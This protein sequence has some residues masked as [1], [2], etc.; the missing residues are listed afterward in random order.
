MAAS[1]HLVSLGAVTVA[2]LAVASAIWCWRSL[3][4][5]RRER[6]AMAEMLE[7]ER[8]QQ[9]AAATAAR[10]S[11][12][13]EREL[14]GLKARFVSLV[15]HEFRTPLGIIMSAVELLKNY[16]DRLPPEKQ[17]ELLEDILASTRRMSSL[18][19]QVL[20]LGRVDAGKIAVQPVPVDL[21]DLLAKIADE[22]RSASGGRCPILVTTGAELGQARADVGL[23]RHIVS[24]LVSNA[25]KYSPDGAEVRV[26]LRR[27]AGFARL[28]V[29]DRGIGIPEAD[30]ARLFEAFHRAGNVGEIPG[31]G[32]GLLIV[33]RCVELHGGRIAVRSRVG[34][35]TTFEVDLPL[36]TADGQGPAEAERAPRSMAS[37]IVA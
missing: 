14:V 12:E 11:L 37:R 13:A 33:K 20:L 36:F 23:L 31:S 34:E 9:T 19:E 27:E 26:A 8:A 24:N 4:L 7:R 30:Q 16:R 3:L 21:P 6:A 17:H 35:G 29:V 22:Q 18:M 25:V 32:L 28:D 10:A 1:P 5:A 15:S 2:G